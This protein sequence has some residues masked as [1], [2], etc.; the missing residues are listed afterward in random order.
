MA[1]LMQN[2]RQPA[3]VYTAKTNLEANDVY[4]QKDSN[5]LRLSYFVA[6]SPEDET[7]NYKASLAM[8]ELAKHARLSCQELCS[9][10]RNRC[11]RSR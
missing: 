3:T 2:I 11:C 7:T 6:R 1:L 8:L 4:L 10:C 5:V 9:D